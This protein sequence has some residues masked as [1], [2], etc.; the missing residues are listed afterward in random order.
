VFLN[1]TLLGSHGAAAGVQCQRR[2][3]VM[4]GKEFPATTKPL[5]SA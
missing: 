1:Q 4:P 3:K 5:L 2:Q